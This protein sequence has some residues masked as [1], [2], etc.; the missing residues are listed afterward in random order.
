MSSCRTGSSRSEPRGAY[1]GPFEN[2]GSAPTTLVVGTTYDPGTANFHRRPCG[3]RPVS[4]TGGRCRGRS[5]ACVRPGRAW[6]DAA[7]DAYLE[8]GTLPAEGTVCRQEVAFE[9]PQLRGLARARA[10]RVLEPHAKPL[11]EEQR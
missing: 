2:R 1:Y 10:A 3:C 9:A 8:E 4:S 11:V 7:V 5:P 6:I